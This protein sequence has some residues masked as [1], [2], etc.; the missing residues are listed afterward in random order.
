MTTIS[1]LKGTINTSFSLG[2]G[3]TLFTGERE[4]NSHLGS[5]GDLYLQY[6]LEPETENGNPTP[7]GRLYI[8]TSVGENQ[9]AWIYFRNYTFDTPII[10]ETPDGNNG[11][12]YNIAIQQAKTPETN[13][14]ESENINGANHNLYGVVRFATDEEAK[15]GKLNNVAISPVTLQSATANA[16]VYHGVWGVSQATV[17]FDF[18]EKYR[19]SLPNQIIKGGSMFFVGSIPTTTNMSSYT[20]YFAEENGKY[21]LYVR[22]YRYSD[23]TYN[24]ANITQAI[25][26]TDTNLP[27]ST[28]IK[29]DLS[30]WATTNGYT[31]AENVSVNGTTYQYGVY[32]TP[33]CKINDIE[34][35]WGDHVI[36]EEDWAG[37]TPITSDI[38]NKF[39]GSESPD[40]VRLRA[41]QTL[42]NKKIDTDKNIIENLRIVRNP[43]NNE[44][45]DAGYTSNFAD[46]VIQKSVRPFKTSSDA[47]IATEKAVR[48]ELDTKPSAVDGDLTTGNFLKLKEIQTDD[49][50]HKVIVG[51]WVDYIPDLPIF[52]FDYFDHVPDTTAWVQSTTPVATVISGDTFTSAYATL[53]KNYN[54]QNAQDKEDT[55]NV[56]SFSAWEWEDENG[57]F[58]YTEKQQ[59]VVSDYLYTYNK[60]TQ[61][62]SFYQYDVGGVNLE[63]AEPFIITTETNSSR[64]NATNQK[65]AGNISITISYKV[66][67]SATGGKY[68]ICDMSLEKTLD[69]LFKITGS[70]W[71]YQIDT[72]HRTFR[73]PCSVNYFRAY[74]N[75]SSLNQN[76][77]GLA[78]ETKTVDF[79]SVWVSGETVGSNMSYTTM[80]LYFYLG[81]TVLYETTVNLQ[82]IVDLLQGKQNTLQAEN[83]SIVLTTEGGITKIRANISETGITNYNDLN[84]LPSINGVTLSGNKLS[85][86]DLNIYSINDVNA[87]LGNYY[88]KAEIDS[89]LDDVA[90]M[91]NVYTKDEIDNKLQDIITTDNVYT[92]IETDSLISQNKSDILNQVYTKNETYSKSESD[93]LLSQKANASDVYSIDVLDMK[94]SQKADTS[95]VNGKEDKS[96]KT[97]NI[98]AT[99]TAEQYP[100]A[101]AVWEA[102]KNLRPNVKEIESYGL[103]NVTLDKAEANT[104][105]KYGELSNLTINDFDVSNLETII[106]FKSSS[107]YEVYQV[108]TD[109]ESTIYYVNVEGSAGEEVPTGTPIYSEKEC[110]NVVSISDTLYYNGASITMEE[111]GEIILPPNIPTIGTINESLNNSYYKLSIT[112]GIFKLEEIDGGQTATILANDG[113]TI[114]AS[115]S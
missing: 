103:D 50:G 94:L 35:R 40:I 18:F 97:S 6:R 67:A 53:L 88:K 2:N 28:T 51:E 49:S 19:L 80:Y 91:D 89:K 3:C 13:I 8:K 10:T 69:R 58:V 56:T 16:I 99:S 24:D 87:L 25:V 21:I 41:H 100:N 44:T 78:G 105:Y 52:K 81:N 26:R 114:I 39:D 62:F 73:L 83:N 57:N 113:S 115:I 76:N 17:D 23:N 33:Y 65:Q 75:D 110:L 61:T 11:S 32:E 90:N 84:N 45:G 109:S 79:G 101:L 86:P 77:D 85:N 34:Y 42:L 63:N 64:F 98:S 72:T 54:S 70:A 92:K 30:H 107:H 74:T 47:S 106:Y 20:G 48:L 66:D 60:E 4:P 111:G 43:E 102:I 38:L 112:N 82:N 93:T 31:F 95:V 46:G 55:I 59:P 29:D 68:K 15:L 96:N 27:V 71:Y 9:S 7:S 104:V 37:N 14:G 108:T 36:F 1:N 22:E 12:V 5:Y